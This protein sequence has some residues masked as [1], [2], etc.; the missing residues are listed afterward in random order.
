VTAVQITQSNGPSPWQ[1]EYEK[2]S[3]ESRRIAAAAEAAE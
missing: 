2:F 1:Q 3:R